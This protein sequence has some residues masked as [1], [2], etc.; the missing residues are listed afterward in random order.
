MNKE[1]IVIKID[2]SLQ[3]ERNKIIEQAVSLGFITL[4]D[5]KTNYEG[6]Y[7]DHYGFDGFINYLSCVIVSYQG[8]PKDTLSFVTEGK[9]LLRN[10]IALKKKFGVLIFTTTEMLKRM[11]KQKWEKGKLLV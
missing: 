9:P 10:R 11:E 8:N 5:Y 1:K 2:K 6:K 4:K 3:K 7:I